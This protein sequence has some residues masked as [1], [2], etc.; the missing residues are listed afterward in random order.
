MGNVIDWFIPEHL[1]DEGGVTYP[2]GGA[3]AGAEGADQPVSQRQTVLVIDDDP[4][5]R[6]LLCRVLQHEGFHV[7]TAASGSEGLLLAEQLVPCAITLDVMMPSMDG[8]TLLSE[9]KAH[10]DLAK[11]PVVIITIVSE[12][13]R[14]YALG[15]DHYLVKTVDRGE[16][17]AVMN[18]YRRRQVGRADPTR[19]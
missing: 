17:V 8:W 16:L 7:V 6:D 4:S 12:S 15:A 14:G 5:V 13:A 9:L 11:I 18:N 3:E 10:P 19:Q 1:T 2:I